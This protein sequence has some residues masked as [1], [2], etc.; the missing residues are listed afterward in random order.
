MPAPALFKV[1]AE[2]VVREALAAVEHD[3]ARII[4]G[5]FVWAVMMI[6]ALVPMALLRIA[7]GFRGRKFKGH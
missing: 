7:L 1:T 4:P 2:Q 5:W 3:R 6:T